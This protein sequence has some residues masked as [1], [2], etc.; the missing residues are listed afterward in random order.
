L[1]IFNPFVAILETQ[2]NGALYSSTV[3][4]TQAVD[5]WAVIFGTARRGLG[6]ANFIL[7]N[8]AIIA[9]AYERVKIPRFICMILAHFRSIWF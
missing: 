4:G 2:S 1:F 8:V 6:G 7:F 9:S 5:G 3:I